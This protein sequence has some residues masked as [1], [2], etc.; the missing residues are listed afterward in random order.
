MPG[1]VTKVQ[2][3]LF[4]GAYGLGERSH[5]YDKRRTGF[6]VANG[7]AEEALQPSADFNRN[8]QIGERF[9]LEKH[10]AGHGDQPVIRKIHF[11]IAVRVRNRE[12]SVGEPFCGDKRENLTLIDGCGDI[13]NLCAYGQRQSDENKHVDL[14]SGF[15][16]PEQGGKGTVQQNPVGEQVIAA[17][18]RER[19][20]RKGQNTDTLSGSVA[21]DRNYTLGVIVR[22]CDPDHR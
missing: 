20:L 10:T 15:C 14:R 18:A 13:V 5:L 12:V 3:R 2:F 21:N 16:N 11:V 9:V 6:G 1:F 19:E 4:P 22:V 8:A 7:R 17:A